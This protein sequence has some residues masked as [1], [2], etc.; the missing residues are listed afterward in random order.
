MITLAS[1]FAVACFEC[2]FEVICTCVG[3]VL[4]LCMYVYVCLYLCWIYVCICMYLHLDVYCSVLF[5]L[6]YDM[7]LVGNQ[8]FL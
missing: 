4:D 3:V 2:L 8:F 6:F 1:V 7:R 5:V